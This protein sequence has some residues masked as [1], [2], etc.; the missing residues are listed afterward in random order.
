VQQR[1]AFALPVVDTDP[2]PVTDPTAL[3]LTRELRGMAETNAVRTRRKGF[4]RRSTL[5][6]AAALY[7][8][9]FGDAKGRIAATFEV[10]YL[11][12][13]A[14]APDQPKALR[15]G[16]ARARLADALGAA[17]RPSGDKTGRS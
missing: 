10:I 4:T 7:E 1:A 6:R 3:A 8:Q 16:S 15:P 17:E 12:A 14:P 13:W 9:K 11:T 5:L 2:I